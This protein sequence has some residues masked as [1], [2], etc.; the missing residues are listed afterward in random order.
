MAF[1]L[2]NLIANV[3]YSIYLYRESVAGNT[4]SVVIYHLTLF[5]VFLGVWLISR[6]S[7]WSH[8]T[9]NTVYDPLNP[10]FVKTDDSDS[11]QQQPAVASP[12]AYP[13]QYQ[14]ISQHQAAA[15]NAQF[16]QTAYAGAGGWAQQSNG[17]QP[18][19]QNVFAPP[20]VE[21]GP[22]HPAFRAEL[23]SSRRQ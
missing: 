7:G 2:D 20:A 9:T 10:V 16:P 21:I 8:S 13:T 5:L 1:S 18:V 14:N 19:Q 3:L 23:E 6:A 4:V 11:Q 22:G 12:T 15:Y 17:Y